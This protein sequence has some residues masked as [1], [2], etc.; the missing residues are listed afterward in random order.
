MTQTQTLSPSVDLRRGDC[1]EIMRSIDDG[2]IDMVLADLPY[3]TTACK[4]DTT[5]PLVP[6]WEQYKRIIKP[7]GAIVL[8]AS[9][10]FSSLLVSSNPRWFRHEWIWEKP[11]PTGFQFAKYAPMRAH[12]SVLVFSRQSSNYGPIMLLRDKPIKSV[13]RQ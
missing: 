10:P 12:E 6:L 5:I 11:R 13:I 4:W 9:Q 3:G 7:N 2:S 1:L 8:T